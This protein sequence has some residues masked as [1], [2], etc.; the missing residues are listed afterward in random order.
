MFFP[1]NWESIVLAPKSHCEHSLR[2][3]CPQ[4]APDTAQQAVRAPTISVLAIMLVQVNLTRALTTAWDQM[5]LKGVSGNI[6]PRKQGF[7][8]GVQM[9]K[10][11][12]R[13]TGLREES[14]NKHGEDTALS[15]RTEA[16]PGPGGSSPPWLRA[17]HPASGFRS[18]LMVFLRK[19]EGWAAG[20]GSHFLCCPNAGRAL[21]LARYCFS[22][23]SQPVAQARSP[24]CGPGGITA[25][26]HGYPSSKPHKGVR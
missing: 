6:G 5:I 12:Q 20:C 22:G 17:P 16:L 23:S 26:L 13:G 8:S 24:G 1:V 11:R 18:A 10:G 25:L 3:G 15:S 19:E 7:I 14:W 2:S 9:A 4:G 21:N